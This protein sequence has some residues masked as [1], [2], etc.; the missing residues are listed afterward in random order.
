MNDKTSFRAL[1][2][3][4]LI[5]FVVVVEGSMLSLDANINGLQFV[6]YG[7]GSQSFIDIYNLP[8]FMRVSF[9][10]VVFFL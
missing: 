9:F 2:I 7:S 10:V 8:V 4:I 1:I 3:I 5:F 6:S